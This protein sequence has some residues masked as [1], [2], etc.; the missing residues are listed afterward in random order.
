MASAA[1]GRQHLY[2][3][4]GTVPLPWYDEDGVRLTD[5]DGRPRYAANPSPIGLTWAWVHVDADDREVDRGSGMLVC[6][7]VVD[8]QQISAQ[9]DVAEFY[10]LLVGL[11]HLTR[12]APG[13]SGEILSDSQ[14]TLDRMFRAAATRSLPISW[15]QEAA[16][17]RRLL[18]RLF[19]VTLKGHP[20]KDELAQGHE[21]EREAAPARP[22]SRWN[23]LADQLCRVLVRPALEAYHAQHNG[24]APHG[25]AQALADVLGTNAASPSDEQLPRDAGARRAARPGPG[26]R[27]LVR[28]A[29]GQRTGVCAGA[30]RRCWHPGRRPGSYP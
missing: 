23:V 30:R 2:A 5:E 27:G 20:R 15:V 16:A 19:P 25:I 6:P 22:V 14:L 10:A 4:G 28:E 9:S 7:I 8:G 12:V 3:D 18:G 17:H 21:R 13:W 1:A 24:T 11:R 26:G 29:R